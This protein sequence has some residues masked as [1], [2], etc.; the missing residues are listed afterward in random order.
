MFGWI[1]RLFGKEESLEIWTPGER[2]IFAY[3]DGQ[4]VRK[5]DPIVLYKELMARGPEIDISRKVA[6]SESKD[7]LKAHGD[8]V[9][10][11]R[12][13]FGVQT[14]AGGGLT[15]P[16]VV[17][18]LDYFLGYVEDVKKKCPSP[19]TSPG[20]TSAA[21][22]SSSAKGQ[23]IPPSSAFGSTASGNSTSKRQPSPSAPASPTAS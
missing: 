9:A 6:A 11:I 18:L 7:A 21:M 17:D 23:A 22:A 10:L 16:E 13:V 15:D 2:R 20:A 4:Q 14:L 8:L 1:R 12:E 5:A 19:L 3:F